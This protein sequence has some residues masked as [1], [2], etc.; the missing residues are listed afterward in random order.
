MNKTLARRHRQS[1]IVARMM[2]TIVALFHRDYSRKHIG[3]VFEELLV[4]MAVRDH[5]EHGDGVPI[6]VNGIAKKLGVP[7]SNV[8]RAV[9]R[10]IHHGVIE[11]SEKGCRGRLDYLQARIDAE[12]FTGIVRAVIEAADELKQTNGRRLA[13]RR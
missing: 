3:A 8:I 11:R 1:A 7:R 4:A 9:A 6:S 2:L 5:D 13:G 12:Y 10:L